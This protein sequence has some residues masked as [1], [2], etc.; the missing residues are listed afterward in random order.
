MNGWAKTVLGALCIAIFVG[1]AEVFRQ[2]RESIS[3][4]TSRVHMIET[5]IQ[6]WLNAFSF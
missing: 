1:I 3:D 2:L 4:L 5:T 6:N